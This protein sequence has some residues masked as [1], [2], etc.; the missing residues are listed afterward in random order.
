MRPL[1]ALLAMLAAFL[2]SDARAFAAPPAPV[3]A[4][5]EALVPFLDGKGAA[6]EQFAPVFLAQVPE[7]QIAAIAAQLRDQL[8]AAQRVSA[9]RSEAPGA[10]TVDLAYARGTVTMRIVVDA[11]PPHLITGLLITGTRLADDS[12]D[13]LGAEFRALPGSSGFAVARLAGSTPQMVAEVNGN[14]AFAIGSAFKLYVLAE[15]VRS[16][17]AGTRKWSDVVPLT[18]RSL[19]SGILQAWPRDAPVTLHTLA[20]L[21]VSRSDNTATDRLIGVLGRGRVEAMQAIAGHSEPARN[22]PFLTTSELFLLKGTGGKALL[23]RWNTGDAAARTKVLAELAKIDRT[24]FD[25]G[26]FSG[27]PLAIDTAEWFASP[28]DLIRA[29]DWIRRNDPA[30]GTARNIL[31]INPGIGAA[32]HRYVGYKG[33]SEAGVVSANFLVQSKTGAWYAVAGSWNDPK[34]AVD[35]TRFFTLMN[36]AVT[37]GVK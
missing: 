2:L 26:S 27:P 24:K 19:P 28:S 13:K 15:L 34:A 14:R 32:D 10:A 33:G 9:I 36:R 16:V 22:R 20:A 31:T 3:A 1:L 4:R 37:L 7:T 12:F 18:E 17:N 35:E 6:S 30:A 25:Y 21:M 23:E 29:L 8:G 11:T 5:A